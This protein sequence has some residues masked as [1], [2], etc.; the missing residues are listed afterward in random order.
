MT[1]FGIFC[2][3]AIGH[4][5]PT[6]AIALEL[7][8]R[9]QIVIL[10][11]VSDAL[12]KV[13]GL[14]LATVEI[15]TFDY[16][17]G[18]VDSAYRTLGKLTGKPGLKCTIN[19]FKRETQMFFRE[20][21]QAIRQANIDVLI[22]DQ[23]SSSIATVADYLGLPF[24]TVCNAMLI[25]REPGVPPYSMRQVIVEQRRDW[26][27]PQYQRREDAYSPLAQVC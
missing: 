4:L 8:R 9:G 18:S 11:G 24:V 5:N 16:P 15:G 19:F 14:N 22:I 6:C 13:S 21:P 7:Q 10:F 26:N 20:A 3:S 25:N 12:D 2:P 27:L 17:K 23:I 1:R